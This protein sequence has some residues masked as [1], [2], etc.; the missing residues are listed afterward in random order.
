MATMVDTQGIKP[1]FFSL[2]L[3]PR[4][5]FFPATLALV[6]FLKV[7][8]DL[9][10]W[11]LALI[12]LLLPLYYFVVPVVVRR[13]ERALERDVL[14]LLQQGKRD[15]LL[16]A[17]RKRWILRLLAPADRMQKHLA[18]MYTEVGDF[19]RAAACYERA[20]AKARP[21][22]RLGVLLGLA[23]ARY[24]AGDYEGAE[25]VYRE[26][27]RRGQQLPEV[28]AGL[29]HSLLLQERDL[30]EALR[31]ARRSVKGAADG[32]S[33]V[34]PRLTLAEAL[35]ARG[36]PGKARAELEAAEVVDRNDWLEA[37]RSWVTAL[38]AENDGDD[39]EAR[40]LFDDVQ[41]LD[42]GGLGDLARA[43]LADLEGDEHEAG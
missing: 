27:L 15:R 8:F 37:R 39:D 43:R 28:L 26:L 24:R 3:H 2:K 19:A 10:L 11:G 35:L 30:G 18:F 23:Q 31:L 9:P 41:R 16:A 6:F 22:E 36:K 38:L 12:L 7:K 21:G 40:E 5:L 17:Y 29:A 32:P 34:P 14:R 33:M 42:R 13:Q 20:A 25:I 1:R 4:N